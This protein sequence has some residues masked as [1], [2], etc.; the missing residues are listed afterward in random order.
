MPKT[1]NQR[2]FDDILTWA[3]NPLMDSFR[4]ITAA[5]S[6]AVQTQD[7][8]A[9]A[10]PSMILLQAVEE[11]NL[12]DSLAPLID[13]WKQ[14]SDAVAP[15]AFIPFKETE[16][17]ALR[18]SMEAAFQAM[19]ANVHSP[20]LQQVN[21]R[22]LQ[23]LE[24]PTTLAEVV[25]Q[26]AQVAEEVAQANEMEGE[27]SRQAHTT[28]APSPSGSSPASQGAGT[29]THKPT[30]RA[31]PASRKRSRAASIAS[32]PVPVS[33]PVLREE[34]YEADT[35][36]IKM[37][38]EHTFKAADNSAAEQAHP[39]APPT[40]KAARQPWTRDQIIAAATLMLY[41]LMWVTAVYTAVHGSGTV[42]VSPPTPVVPSPIIH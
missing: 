17:Q 8:V 40:T 42:I 30:A 4:Q 2:P 1:N 16:L 32:T 14:M 24:Q 12:L 25:H 18:A 34:Q 21:T 37:M 23:T 6:E 20:R 9:A 27:G 33:S 10:Q 31:R 5:M 41:F 39:A 28:S 35:A 26:V 38:A 15:Q 13:Q 7:W 29:R 36:R 19:P 22:L 3:T 11:A